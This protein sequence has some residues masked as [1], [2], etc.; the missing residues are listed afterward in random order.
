K[1]ALEAPMGL[2]WHEVA[3]EWW[4]NNVSCDDM[5]DLWIHEAF[6]TYS[7]RLYMMALF[8]E[9]GE[10]GFMEGL[11]EQVLG[12]EPIVGVYNVNHIH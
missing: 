4:G 6:A 8:G 5:A 12:R 7:E 2:I 1:E 10:A 3:H 11:P 9:K